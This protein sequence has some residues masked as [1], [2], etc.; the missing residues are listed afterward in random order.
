MIRRKQQY[1]V[2]RVERAPQSMTTECNG[3]PL[4]TDTSDN[5]LATQIRSL[6]PVHPK[7]PEQEH[8]NMSQQ[9]ERQISRVRRKHGTTTWGFKRSTRRPKPSNR[10]DAIRYQPATYKAQEGKRELYAKHLSVRNTMT[11]RSALRTTCSKSKRR[12]D[13]NNIVH[14]IGSSPGNIHHGEHDKIAYLI[15]PGL[16][17]TMG[18]SMDIAAYVMDYHSHPS[19]PPYSPELQGTTGTVANAASDVAPPTVQ[20]AIQTVFSIADHMLHT[21]AAPCCLT[22]PVVSPD[23]VIIDN[24]WWRVAELTTRYYDADHKWIGGEDIRV[25]N[26]ENRTVSKQ[27]RSRTVRES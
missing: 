19:L 12:R 21:G 14:S 13:I 4:L 5:T 27:A 8:E 9:L 10:Y 6:G 3:P 18:R 17:I 20:Q 24:F 22:S 2:I 23:T 1:I 15:L 7:F 26:H 25:W 16:F 11:S